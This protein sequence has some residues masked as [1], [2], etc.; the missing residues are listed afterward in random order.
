MQKLHFYRSC[1]RCVW[2][3]PSQLPSRWVFKK[4]TRNCLLTLN[5]LRNLEQKTFHWF[6]QIRL[7]RRPRY[8]FERK[9]VFLD[10]YKNE[11]FLRILA[12]S[13]W[14][15]FP[16]LLCTCTER[17]SG[18]KQLRILKHF[19]QFS[20]F[21]W[22]IFQCFRLAQ[23]FFRNSYRLSNTC[24]FCDFFFLR[25]VQNELYIVGRTVCFLFKKSI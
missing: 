19:H 12:R 5:V 3:V 13:V 24:R 16:E 22:K 23:F 17:L 10:S 18:P 2:L 14:M 7:Y 8:H 11:V 1:G 6:C 21:Q 20:G 25:V 15:V 4:R 9:Q